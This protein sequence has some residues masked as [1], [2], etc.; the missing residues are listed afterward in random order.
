MKRR[1]LVV[2]WEDAAGPAS[3]GWT[4]VRDHESSRYRCRTVGWVLKETRTH[5]VLVSNF[6][7]IDDPGGGQMCGVMEIPTRMIK[8]KRVLRDPFRTFP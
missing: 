3:E 8:S 7:S 1:L 6:G 4:H 2:E 5:L